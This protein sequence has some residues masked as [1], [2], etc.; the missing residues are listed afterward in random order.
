MTPPGFP[1]VDC[2]ALGVGVGGWVRWGDFESSGD[3]S[4][5]GGWQAGFPTVMD[6]NSDVKADRSYIRWSPRGSWEIRSN[7]SFLL[8]SARQA[9]W[10]AEAGLCWVGGMWPPQESP[11][12]PCF[13]SLQSCQLNDCIMF[14]G[15]GIP[16][17]IK[18]LP[19]SWKFRLFPFF[20]YLEFVARGSCQVYFF[21]LQFIFLDL[22][23]KIEV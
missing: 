16:W 2:Q 9:E 11:F 5:G 19:W 6:R 10:C 18:P 17:I 21:L 13:L 15:A 20:C 1:R 7:Y 22:F 12:F 8:R 23:L 4:P 14:C 3:N